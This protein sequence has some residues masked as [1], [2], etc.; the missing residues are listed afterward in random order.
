MRTEKSSKIIFEFEILPPGYLA[1]PIIVCACVGYYYVAPKDRLIWVTRVVDDI[2]LVDLQ[3]ER[4]V[5]LKMSGR[6]ALHFVFKIGDRNQTIKFYKDVLG[7]KVLVDTK[8]GDINF[9]GLIL[10][11]NC[12]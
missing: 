11:N 5:I 4:F 10:C 1:T 9:D 12:F 7:M 2:I 3:R 8:N 6:R